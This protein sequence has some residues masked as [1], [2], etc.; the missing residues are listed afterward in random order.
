[1]VMQSFVSWRQL[2][3]LQPTTL[4]CTSANWH[5]ATS[6]PLTTTTLSGGIYTNVN[7]IMSNDSKYAVAKKFTNKGRAE[8]LEFKGNLKDNPHFHKFKLRIILFD[9]KLYP[10]AV[11]RQQV[12]K[13]GDEK[14]AAADKEAR[15]KKFIEACNE[16]AFAILMINIT[17][18]TLKS[19]LRRT[20]LRRR[21]ASGLDVH[22]RTPARGQG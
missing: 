5:Q 16:D 3:Q 7:F 14:V 22:L 8:F 6:S 20:R 11:G 15:M 10:D 12:K 4:T 17:D 1:M 2:L 19:R 18:T 21:R 9:D 13:L